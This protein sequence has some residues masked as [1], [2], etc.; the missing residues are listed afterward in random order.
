MMLRPYLARVVPLV[1]F[2]MVLTMSVFSVGGHTRIAAAASLTLATSFD[3]VIAL[4]GGLTRVV[5]AASESST[6]RGAT[7][8]PCR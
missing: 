1:T 3:A 7:N 5:L 2:L 4:S 8:L 6:P